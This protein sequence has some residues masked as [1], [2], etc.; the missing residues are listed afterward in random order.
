MFTQLKEAFKPAIALI[1]LGIAI[2]Y[3]IDYIDNII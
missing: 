1:L 2:N 3:L